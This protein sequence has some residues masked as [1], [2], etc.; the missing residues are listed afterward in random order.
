MGYNSEIDVFCRKKTYVY[1]ADRLDWGGRIF[2]SAE[3]K[4][5]GGILE[6]KEQCDEQ[7]V[8]NGM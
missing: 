6:G 3:F 2:V 8:R 5:C 4:G 1:M 7:S